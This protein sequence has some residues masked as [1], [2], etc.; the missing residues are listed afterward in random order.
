MESL[1]INDNIKLEP[2]QKNDA[3]LAKILWLLVEEFGLSMA[4]ASVLIDV[5][6]RTL[7]QARKSK[8]LPQPSRDRYRRI[9]LL[10]GIKK[11]LEIL[12]PRNPEVRRNWLHIPR[13]TFKEKSAISMIKDSPLE[14]MSRLFT[15]RRLLDMLR[16]GTIHSIT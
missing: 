13:E 4:D 15:V 10:L 5:K 8:A 16:N 6:K 11:N 12:F 1:A 14:S 2:S 7:Y 9:G 3:I